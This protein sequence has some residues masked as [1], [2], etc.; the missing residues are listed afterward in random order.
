MEW[1]NVG[2]IV[3]THGIKGE[4]RV[5][6]ITDFPDSRFRVG[7]RL[8]FFKEGNNEP[9][10]LTIKSRRKHK[11]FILLQFEECESV[12]DAEA[13]KGG[14]L[15]IS[16]EQRDRSELDEHEFYYHEII[17][18]SVFSEEGTELGKVKEIL[19]PGANDVWVV[20]SKTNGKP[21]YVPYIEP[22]VKEVNVAERKITIHVMEGLME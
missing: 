1:F 14:M 19:S 21:I 4:V 5:I 11:Q 17:G 9:L 13:L 10:P 2:K 20:Q 8:Y 7:N 15:K 6:P 12:N 16:V 18:C 22:I 3:N